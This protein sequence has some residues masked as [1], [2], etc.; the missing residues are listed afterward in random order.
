MHHFRNHEI[1]HEIIFLKECWEQ[2]LKIRTDSYQ[3]KWKKIETY[4]NVEI[5]EL[6][7]VKHFTKNEAL[8]WHLRL[9]L[10]ISLTTTVHKLVTKQHW[11]IRIKTWRLWMTLT[12]QMSPL[13]SHLRNFCTLN[14]AKVQLLILT[15]CLALLHQLPKTMLPQSLYH[16]WMMQ[17]PGTRTITMLI[18]T[19]T[20]KITQ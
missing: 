18:K 2:F 4:E 1:S 19:S 7:T 3:Q 17:R 9:I 14:T 10:L 6:T 12:S 8:K 11:P 20:K 13:R 16:V 15:I 5:L